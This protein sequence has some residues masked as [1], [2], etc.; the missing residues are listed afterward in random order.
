MKT[1]N[2]VLSC[3]L[4]FVLCHSCI[5]DEGNYDYSELTQVTINSLPNYWTAYLGEEFVFDP[6]IDYG[7][8][9]ST[10]FS[11]IW[12]SELQDEW[13]DTVCTEK[14]LRY[15]WTQMGGYW[16]TFIVKH[17]PTG[18]LTA[19]QFYLT[20]SSQYSTG[21]TILSEEN[22]TSVLSYIRRESTGEDEASYT[23][24]KDI[25]AELQGEPLG[26]GPI[27]LGRHYSDEMDEIFVI[28]ESG[29]VEISGLDFSKQITTEEEFV[30]GVYPAGFEPKQA[31]YASLIDAILGT[32]GNVYVRAN[33]SS[34]YS[35]HLSQY[36]DVPA[37][38]N[39]RIS[40]LFYSFTGSCIFAHDEL[41][42]RMLA[43][44]DAP[45][46]YT[47]Q[48]VYISHHPD[49][50]VVENFTPLDDMGE[51]TEIAFMDCYTVEGAG[52][53]TWAQIIKKDGD[54]YFR[55]Y[56]T[57]LVNGATNM[58]TFNETEELFVGN[59]L[60]DDDSKYCL[61][62]NSYLFFSS[63]NTLYYWNMVTDPQIF[64]TFTGGDIV[65]MERYAYG[66]REEIGVGLDNGEF[67]ILNATYEAITGQTEKIIWQTEGLGTIV[68]LQ[69]KY[70]NSSNFED[71]TRR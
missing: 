22:G 3:L 37:F 42:N 56:V 57:N 36:G 66:T 48:I 40:Q 51:G 59:D 20:I 43:I 62:G 19:S 23:L 21:W 55:T 9:D 53:T 31:E 67:Y 50:A 47:G 1:F 34:P 29:A 26:T 28:Q 46:A 68:D 25:Y 71:E 61:D 7:D 38:S 54:Y 30:G 64:Y 15:T 8:A 6:D 2:I 12:I 14:E 35:L 27:R 18:A 45:Q 33:P 58:Y 10:E 11:Y 13:Q 44:Y 32:D 4:A 60:V 16:N 69:Y 63:G 39:A 24:I 41:N 5:D 52:G 70:S 17:D 49:S 65:D